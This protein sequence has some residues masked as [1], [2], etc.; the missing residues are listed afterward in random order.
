[1]ENHWEFGIT[2]NKFDFKDIERKIGIKF[3]DHFKSF[4]KKV[5]GASP[6]QSVITISNKK[7]I[8]NDI[9]DFNI[10]CEYTTEEI[11]NNL[12]DIIGDYYPFARDGFGNYYLINTENDTVQFYNHEFGNVIFLCSF[13]EFISYLGVNIG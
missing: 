2:L 6:K 5:N 1:M 3:S 10:N 11:Y 9:L 13:D 8:L 7:Y 12:R 4:I